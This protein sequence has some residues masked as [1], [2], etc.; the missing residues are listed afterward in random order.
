M[1]VKVFK[2]QQTHAHF[3][4]RGRFYDTL[5]VCVLDELEALCVPKEKIQTY[6]SLSNLYSAI[7]FKGIFKRYV[8]LI[9]S[10]SLVVVCMV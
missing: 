10:P 8:R 6:I 7:S 2:Q 5:S 1:R 4:T 9:P 3:L